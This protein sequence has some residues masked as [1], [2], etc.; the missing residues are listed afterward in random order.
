MKKP[1]LLILFLSVF[2]DLIGFGIVLPLLPIYSK[3]FGATGFEIGLIIASFSVMQFLFAPMWGRL[4]DRIGRRPVI[5]ISNAGSAVSYSLFAVAST[6]VG[7]TGLWLLLASRV[8]AGIC[9]ANLAVA[10]AYIADVTPPEQ[11]TQ[12]MGLIGMAFGFG[13]IFGPALGAFSF[14]RFGLPGPGW[15]AAAFCAFNFLL[16]YMVLAESWKPHSDRAPTRPA[17]GQWIQVMNRPTVGLVIGLY[18]LATFCFACF[19]STFSLLVKEKFKYDESHAGYLFAYCGVLAAV[20]QAGLIGRLNKH[21]GEQR[22]IFGSLILLGVSL[23]LLPLTATL[24]GLLL[25]LAVFAVGSGVNRPPTFGL[26]S[27]RSSAE[28]QGSILGVA[29]SIA[30]LARIVAPIFAN[31]LYAT[32]PALPYLV[33]AGVALAAGLAAWQFLCRAEPAAASCMQ[34]LESPENTARG[35]RIR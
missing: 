21:F 9:G 17:L 14:A 34:N 7:Q 30:S 25:V 4:S 8:F 6:M 26:I 3:R 18:F 35:Q 24:T 22:L 31:V 28:E 27:L 16:G 33:C 29:Q 12:R 19:E 5:L 11:R 15:T 10:N 32:K 2:V 20:I 1:S 13:F 23:A